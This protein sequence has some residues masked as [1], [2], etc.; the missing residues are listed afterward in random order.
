L[1]VLLPTNG[2]HDD[3][4]EA[5]HLCAQ[6]HEFLLKNYSL[7]FA[8]NLVRMQS[9]DKMALFPQKKMTLTG[10]FKGIAEDPSAKHLA[11]GLAA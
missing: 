6:T 5:R 4:F 1:R 11:Q 8:E 2:L 10:K 9:F 3:N 7:T